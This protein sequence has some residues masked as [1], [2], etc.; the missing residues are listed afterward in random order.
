MIISDITWPLERAGINVTVDGDRL[1][2][3]IWT[4]HETRIGCY[5]GRRVDGTRVVLAGTEGV[6]A[7]ILGLYA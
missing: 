1:I 5:E 3:K 4:F 2:Y 7:F 6:V